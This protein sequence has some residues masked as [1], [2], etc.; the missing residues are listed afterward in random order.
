MCR[1][2]SVGEGA[3]LGEGGGSEGRTVS[4]SNDI[5]A[6]DAEI[7]LEDTANTLIDAVYM[8]R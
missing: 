7:G 5:C 8:A 4:K 6:H 1:W 3:A 2:R